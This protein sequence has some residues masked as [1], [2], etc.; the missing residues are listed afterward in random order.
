MPLPGIRVCLCAAAAALWASPALGADPAPLPLLRVRLYET[1]VG[2]FERT[3][4]LGGRGVGLPVPAGHLDDAL[5]T[6]VVLSDD[7][8]TRIGGI[9]FASSLSPG[10]ARSLAGLP[11]SED[12][13]PLGLSALLRGLRGANVD[14]ATRGGRVAGRLVEVLDA[15]ASDLEACT[16]EAPPEPGKPAPC[17]PKKHA[18]LVVLGA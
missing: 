4:P 5:K 10:P 12:G 6:L 14:V 7:P 13:A 11:G 15:E 2:Y 8:A 3:G 16:R 18:T 17:I 1:G 9:E